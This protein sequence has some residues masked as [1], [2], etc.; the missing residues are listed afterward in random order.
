MDSLAVELLTA[1][2]TAQLL[3][4]IGE[5]NANRTSTVSC[6]STGAAARSM[7]RLL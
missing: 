4:K 2:T 3:A 6:C 1:T 5:L 7:A